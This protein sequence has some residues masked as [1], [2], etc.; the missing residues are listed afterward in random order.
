MD[1]SRQNDLTGHLRLNDHTLRGMIGCRL[2]S[3]CG[4][5]WRV[6]WPH[7]WLLSAIAVATTHKWLIRRAG[8][9]LTLV[10]KR[11]TSLNLTRRICRRCASQHG[12]ALKFPAELART[13]AS[14]S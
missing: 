7:E 5:V 4:V 3:L 9:L 10:V 12:P 8:I 11:T 13:G 2:S 1:R 14:R 6:P